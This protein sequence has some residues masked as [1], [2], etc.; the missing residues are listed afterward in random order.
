MLK[1]E[2][3]GEQRGASFG[4]AGVV[5]GFRIAGVVHPLALLEYFIEEV[6]YCYNIT[7]SFGRHV[8]DLLTSSSNATH[9]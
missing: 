6:W 7:T 9:V 3:N 2:K 8:C 4:L 5:K 1:C